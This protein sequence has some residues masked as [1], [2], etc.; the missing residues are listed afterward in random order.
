MTL[1]AT[2]SSNPMLRHYF[3]VAHTFLPFRDGSKNR[4]QLPSVR[5]GISVRASNKASRKQ[6]KI[7]PYYG[8]RGASQGREIWISLSVC[9]RT[10]PC[11]IARTTSANSASLVDW[12]AL[13]G[14]T[15]SPTPATRSQ[16]E[17]SYR[18]SIDFFVCTQISFKMK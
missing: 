7:G 9:S 10:A 3:P 6:R 17:G 1:K 4:Q 15:V 12:V 5:S 8:G 14:C 2:S 16:P 11:C 18:M 13:G